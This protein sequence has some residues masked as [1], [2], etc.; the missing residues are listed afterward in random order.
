M[1][2]A[3]QIIMQPV[4]KPSKPSVKFTAFDEPTTTTERKIIIIQIGALFYYCLLIKKE[5]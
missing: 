4:A 5:P 2:V 3:A 1:N